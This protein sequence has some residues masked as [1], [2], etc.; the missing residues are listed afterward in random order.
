MLSDRNVRSCGAGGLRT[1]GSACR[2]PARCCR[3]VVLANT[4]RNE[5]DV[6]SQGQQQDA[7]DRT[8]ISTSQ[9]E[10]N[11]RPAVFDALGYIGC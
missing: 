4:A 6:V 11:E 1:T 8:I 9:G 7:G 10:S 2:R 5:V 3:P